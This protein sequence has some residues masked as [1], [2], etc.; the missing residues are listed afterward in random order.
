MRIVIDMQ[1]AQTNSLISVIGS[2]TLKFTEALIRNRGEHE[3]ILVLNG[4]LSETIEAIRATFDGL[5]AQENI[6]VWHIP[7]PLKAV[8]SENALRTEVAEMVRES[9]LASLKPDV[10]HISSLFEGY[11]YD[12]VTSIGSFDTVTPVTVTLLAPPLNL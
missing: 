7:G 9:F 8:Q 3:I 12:V 1:G 11:L 5:L 10:I 6:K 4:L 2:F